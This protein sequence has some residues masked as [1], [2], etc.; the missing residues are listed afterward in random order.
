[1]VPADPEQAVRIALT[2]TTAPLFQTFLAWLRHT[3]YVVFI[4]NPFAALAWIALVSAVVLAIIYHEELRG[5]ILGRPVQFGLDAYEN[6][7]RLRQRDPAFQSEAFIQRILKASAAVASAVQSRDLASVRSFVSEG[8]AERLA[9]QAAAAA[10]G[11][12][13]L[14]EGHLMQIESD[15]RFDT[16]HVGLAVRGPKGPVLAQVWSFLRRP[17]AKTLSG[18]GL[19]EGC[20]PCCGA[21]ASAGDAVAC[22][23]CKAWIVSAEYDWLL[24]KVT[25]ALGWTPREPREIPGLPILRGLDRE[26]NVQFIEDRASLMFW[27]LQF[28][29]W[30]RAE[31]PLAAVATPEFRND[32]RDRLL[33]ENRFF[34]QVEVLGVELAALQIGESEDKAHVTVRWRGSPAEAGAVPPVDFSHVLILSR[35]ASQTTDGEKGLRSLLCASCGAPPADRYGSTCEYCGKPIY[36]GGREWALTACVPAGDWSPPAGPKRTVSLGWAEGMP[37]DEAL[38]LLVTGMV[39][40]TEQDDEY[41]REVALAF[42]QRHDIPDQ[43]VA[44]LVASARDGSLKLPKPKDSE[45]AERLMQGLVELTLADGRITAKETAFLIEF[46]RQLGLEPDDVRAMLR[47]AY[48]A[49][50]GAS[51]AARMEARL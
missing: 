12:L 24:S 19:L 32:F 9:L 36:K 23:S 3:L 21:P 22:P 4:G 28:A 6:L 5:L 44:E 17:G 18:A 2:G 47:E 15:E 34:R 16:V 45:E 40:G 31:E 27:R 41:P 48:A 14:V 7:E 13:D 11:R 35:D 1:M 10:G 51:D 42:A 50:L 33:R 25:P 39:D 20:C 26:L 46:A 49:K 29:L 38:S 43:R 8:M 37:P 30:R